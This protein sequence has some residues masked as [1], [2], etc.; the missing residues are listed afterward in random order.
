MRQNRLR[1]Q[2]RFIGAQAQTMPCRAQIIKRGQCA[3]V[4]YGVIMRLDIDLLKSAVARL[5]PRLRQVAQL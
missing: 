5:K 3:L 2:Q 1:G 4:N